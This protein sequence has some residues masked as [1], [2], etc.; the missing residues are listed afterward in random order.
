M[1]NSINGAGASAG[2]AGSIGEAAPKNASRMRHALLGS[3]ALLGIALSASPAMAQSISP[4]GGGTVSTNNG[5]ITGGGANEGVAV[6]QNG[7]GGVDVTGVTITNTGNTPTPDGLRVTGAGGQ[8]V[9]IGIISTSTITSQNGDGVSLIGINENIGFGVTAGQTLNVTGINGLR[10]ATTNGSLFLGGTGTVGD[11]VATARTVGTG[12][13]VLIDLTGGGTGGSLGSVSASGFATGI[14]A[15]GNGLS[16]TIEGGSITATSTGISLNSSSNII[17]DSQAAIVAPT[18]ISVTA[19]N[20]ATVTTSGGGTIN[21]T[22]NGV[23]TGITATSSAGTG[24]V[25][26]TVGAAIGGTTGFATGVNASTTG[27]STGTVNVTTTAAI[28]ATGTSTTDY[29]IFAQRTGA[30]GNGTISVGADVTGGQGVLISGGFDISVAAG[31]TVTGVANGSATPSSTGYGVYTGSSL[32]SLMNAGT[33]RATGTNGIGVFNANGIMT[34]NMSGATISGTM[35]GIYNQNFATV[36]NAGTISSS[37]GT[38]YRSFGG[39]LTNTGSI[40]GVLGVF[41]DGNQL[42][43]NNNAGGTIT[44]SAGAGVLL[45]ASPGTSSVFTNAGTITGGSGNQGINVVGGILTFT[46]Q[47][48]GVISGGLGALNLANTN[49]STITLASGSTTTGDILS[50]NTGV[51]TLTVAGLLTGNYSGGTG[52]GVVNFTLASTGSMQGATFGSANDTFT[53][54]GGTI[55]GVVNAGNGSSDTFDSVLGAGNSASVSLSN[56]TGFENYNHLSGTLTL[57]GSRASGPGWNVT[58]GASVTLSGSLNVTSGTGT[59][60]S[61]NGNTSGTVFEVLAS[62][63]ITGFGGLFFNGGPSATLNN[64]GSI[65]VTGVAVQTNGSTAITNSGTLASSG[66]FAIFTG[67]TVASLINSGTV[68]GG[69]N[70]FGVSS[71]FRAMTITNQAGGFITGGNGAILGGSSG[72]GGLLTISNASGAG[73]SGPT[74]I[75]TVGLA[76]LSLTNSGQVV[77]STDA[78]NATGTGAVTITN[79]VGGVIATGTLASASATFTAGGTGSAIVTSGSATVI[80]NGTLYGNAYGFFTTGSSSVLTLTNRGMITSGNLGDAVAAVGTANVLNSGTISTTVFS[81]V[82][83]LGGGSIVNATGGVLT[84]GNDATFGEA[85]QFNSGTASFTNYGSASS[86][87]GKG[88]FVNGA[89]ATTINLHAGSTTGSIQTG[90][91][92]DTVALFNGRGT[93]STATVDGPSGI[94]LQ[95][96]GTLAGA[97]V[98]SIDLGGGTNTLALRG[99][100]DGTAANGAIGILSVSSIA[101]LSV[102]NKL[103][104]GTWNVT[105]GSFNYTGGTNVQGGRLVFVNRT[106]SAG[107]VTISSGATL[108]FN[109]S[110]GT[111]FQDAATFNG[112]GTFVKSGTA[113]LAS[114]SLIS[115]ASGGLIDVQGGRLI[116]SSDGQGRFTGNLASLNIASGANFSTSEALVIVDRLTGTGT[117]ATDVSGNF[118]VGVDNGSATFGGNIV[119]Q[120]GTPGGKLV[121]AGTGTQTLTGANT[122]TGATTI[123]GGTLAIGGTGTIGSTTITNIATFDIAGH[124]GGLSVLNLLGSGT[125]TLGANTLTITNASGTYSGAFTGTGG[126]TKQGA[127]TYNLTGTGNTYSGTTTVSGGT[128]QGSTASFSSASTIVNNANVAFVQA[129]SGTFAPAISGTGVVNVSGLSGSNAVTFTGALT[130]EG[131]VIASTGGNVTIGS[132]G[133]ITNAALPGALLV[134]G[135]NNI[136][137]VAAG[138]SISSTISTGI[139]RAGINGTASTFTVNNAGTISGLIGIFG[140]SALTLINSGI[141]TGT[142]VALSGVSTSNASTVITN[143]NAISGGAQG[144]LLN[145]GGTVFNSGNAS[146]IIATSTAALTDASGI[147]ANGNL[148]LVNEGLINTASTGISYGVQV[149]GVSTITNMAG[150][151]ISGGIGAILLNGAGNVVNLNAGSTTTG[152][153]LATSTTGTNS[154]T[155]AG[156]LTGS[157]NAGSGADTVTFDTTAGSVSGNLV[158][159]DGVDAFVATGTGSATLAGAITGFESLTKNGTGTLTL[160]GANAIAG[161]TTINAGTLALSGTGTL[162]TAA[163]VTNN[164][165]FDIAGLTAGLSIAN[166]VGSGTTA[167][168]SNTLTLANANGTYSGAFT[169]TGGLIKQGAGTYTLS[170]ANTFTGA[171]LIEGGTLAYGANDVLADTV[172]VT[173]NAGTTFDLAGFSDT[174]GTLELFGTLANGGLLTAG[175][176]NAYAGSTIGQAISSGTLNVFG[177]TTLNAATT[178]TPVNINMGTLTTGGANLLADTGSVLIAAGGQLT[179]GGAETIGSLGDIS[180]MGGIVELAGFGLTVGG[181][182]GNSTFSG[183]IQS[184]AAGGG[185]IKTGTGTF[186]LTGTNTGLDTIVINAGAISVASAAN[187]GTTG[188]IGLLGGTLITTASFATDRTFTTGSVAPGG[189]IN[190]ATGTTFTVNNAIT[191]DGAL[192]KSGLGTLYLLAANT[193]FSGDLFVNGGAVRAG[194]V[195]AFGTGTIHLVDP[196]LIYGVTGTYANNILLEVQTPASADPSTLRAESGVVATIAGSITQGTGAGVDPNQPLVIDGPGF[197]VLTNTANNWAGR[198]TITAGSTLQGTTQTISGGDLLVNGT[199]RYFQPNSGTLSLNASGTGNI[200]VSGLGA[201]QTFTVASMLNMTGFGLTAFDASAVAVTG[202]IRSMTTTALILN[203]TGAT[204]TSVL[205]NSGTISGVAAVFAGG[206]AAVTNLNGGIISGTTNNTIRLVGA[207]SSLIN[208]GSISGTSTFS[209]V[210][211]D[212]VGSVINQA[213]G[214]ITNTATAVQFGGASG[215]L[216]NSGTISNTNTNSAV[217]FN[218]TGT[219]TN[220]ASGMISSAN[221]FGVQLIGAAATVNNFGTITAGQVGVSLSGANA[222]VTN[223]G[224]IT[225]GNAIQLVAGGTVT[226]AGTLTSTIGSGV[227]LQATGSVDNQAAGVIQGATNG[228]TYTAGSATINNAGSITGSNGSGL[229]LLGGGTVTNAATGTITGT[230]NAAIL[231]QGGALNL[232]NLGTLTGTTG[233]AAITAGGFNNV[234]ALGDAST[235][236]GSVTTDTGAD[237]LTLDL[238]ATVNGTIDGGAGIDSFVVTGAGISTLGG[239]INNFETLAMNGS[240]TLTLGGA[241]AGFASVAVNSGTLNTTGGAAIDDTATVTVASGATFGVV[242]SETVG[243]LVLAGTLAGTGTLTATSYTLDGATVNGNL[244]VGALLQRSDTSVL[245][246]VSGSTDVMVQG[247]TL[248]LGASNRLADAASVA[249]STGATLNLGA[250]DDTVGTLAL[251]GTLAGTGT[252]TAGQYQLTGATVNANL[253]A[254]ML[255]QLGGTSV[256]NGTAGASTVMINAGTLSLGASNRLADAATVAVSTGATFDLGAF[257]DTV[258]VLA[259][260]GTIAGT[261]T[262]TA[263]QYQVTGATVNGNLGAGTLFQLGGTSTLNGTSAASAVMVNAGTL[264][265]GGNER[266]ADTAVVQVAGGATFNLAGRTETIGSFGGTA[267]GTGTVALGAGRLVA[268]GSNAD[269]G[270]GGNITGSGDLDKVGTGTFTL[271]SNLAQT[272][273][274]N[275]NAGTTLFVGSTAGSVRVQGGTLTGSAA[276]AGNLTVASGTFSPGTTAQPIAMFTAGSFNASGGTLTFDLGGP[277]TGFAADM[278]NVSGATVLSG[279]TVFTRALEPTANYRVSQNYVLLRS[280]ALTGTFAN[281]ASFAPTGTNPDLQWRLRYDLLPNAVVLELRKQIDFMTDLGPSASGNEL[282]VAGALNGGAFMASDDWAGILNTISSQDP[283]TRRATFNSIS[284][285]AIGDISSATMIATSGFTD[286]LR[287]RLAL[288]GGTSGN[289]NLLSGLVGDKQALVALAASTPLDGAALPTD[290]GYA[291]SDGDEKRGGVWL[292]GYGANGRIDGLTGQAGVDTFSAGV[293]GGIDARFGNVTVGGAFA[294][295]Q[296]ETRVRARTSTNEGTLYQGGGYVAYDNG[297]LYGSVIGSYFSGDINARRSVFVGGALFGVA[298]GTAATRGYTAG[299]ALGYR[300]PLSQSLLFTPQVSFTATGVTRGA[301][302]ETGAGGLSLQAA[303]ERREIYAATAEG[304][305]SRPF[306]ALGGT[307]EPYIGGGAIYSFG[308]LDT[309]STNRFSGAPVGTGTFTIE[310]ARLSPVTALVNGGINVRP[311]Q[312]V[313]LGLQAEARLSQRQREERISLNLRIGF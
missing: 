56:L 14:G 288:G 77:G 218:G 67:V 18:G 101:G 149:L 79:N 145:A 193:G 154:Y 134:T 28:N 217:F 260:G 5:T 281:G 88:V 51:R 309:L 286:L 259:L 221:G 235:T 37:A 279:G 205:T 283:A 113:D 26:V 287:Q 226:N 212:G 300:V 174:I 184:N 98:G 272:G 228:V 68:S 43:L 7:P 105:N 266:L 63:S 143:F 179:L 171:L 234:I 129:A 144:V 86:A 181:N 126:L 53:F 200:G 244:G 38:A 50:S 261:G 108:E 155:I 120:N 246:G 293:A 216:D 192:S 40:S 54:Q 93:A 158:G 201:G 277:A 6:Q 313:R 30:A 292:Q 58:S 48:G 84:G 138:G 194:N 208:A 220:R 13:G 310:G 232:V 180:A 256:L 229:R 250:F 267:N 188:S 89:A 130:N 8:G 169:G 124:T 294:V 11:I 83:A 10:L 282:A 262:L 147:Y 302:T 152:D 110:G 107:T 42:A 165:T 133:S 164:A 231:V 153:I 65:S 167:L 227:V 274:L 185:L 100:G 1:A 141:V 303:R 119:N 62:G 150:G 284:G 207:N 238:G 82:N 112:A 177:N 146:S 219:V 239:N 15:T 166:L 251:A 44:A 196:T 206:Q 151:T 60:F 75:S 305:L 240:G 263:S 46:N 257:N 87:I 114:R 189:G 222:T 268:G 299:A 103:D 243:T 172:S 27:S 202:A 24:N 213:G 304:R 2:F 215:T 35:F 22:S 122:Y 197:I 96:A 139:N 247:G 209:G 121:K 132:T 191:G 159:G 157:L 275:L 254:G 94:T 19:A 237:S 242:A 66:S 236:N 245:N 52:T 33:I 168:G 295:S 301:F 182:N 17:L 285:E 78:I 64:A 233:I 176:Y 255:F 47:S 4:A 80:N 125:T 199:L 161:P 214:S 41:V 298:N 210:F 91:G 148:T 12:T 306:N 36:T 128:L 290:A 183:T 69:M 289:A 117:V 296:I 270:F 187:L 61:I 186:T 85:V 9:G 49:S 3:S 230:G 198:T 115:L 249:V 258:G 253:G 45:N 140:S 265:L 223:N 131:G 156:T 252:L 34:T 71:Q 136:V 59:A 163:D 271:A 81:A 162:G 55:G 123:N 273:R 16:L 308:D 74:A 116:G 241:N 135:A 178:A 276:I 224:S 39:T 175:T 203:N 111:Y 195:Q 23:G 173:V 25:V 137:T 307:V 104:S 32:A 297:R 142:D 248:T 170:G 225:G 280:G 73:I 76:G 21:S 95:N 72:Q 264:S 312:N 102:L 70:S 204:G 57:S 106:I 92:N 118:T 90:G 311:S 29:G 127:G 211:F 109:L 269:F 97:T 190:V 278:I 31:A 20:G 291:S 99:I 160:T